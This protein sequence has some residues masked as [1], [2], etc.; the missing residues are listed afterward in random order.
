MVNER[1][2]SIRAALEEERQSLERQLSGEG[3]AGDAAAGT[4]GVDE[5]FADSAHAT[6]ERSQMLSLKDQLESTHAEVVAALERL[7]AGNFGVC[8]RCG[9]EIPLERLEARPTAR[10]CITCKQATS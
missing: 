5:G 1:Y 4:R 7:D 10:L 3:I 8:E 9:N 6:A 2:E